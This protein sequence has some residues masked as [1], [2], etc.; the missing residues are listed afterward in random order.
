MKKQL[1]IT[2]LFIILII[3]PV[4]SFGEDFPLRS[5]YPS[6]HPIA[7][8]DLASEFNKGIIIVDVRSKMEYNVIH[9][10][11]SL[12]IPWGKESYS[13]QLLKAAK[14]NKS[15]KI[16]VYCNG[17]TCA[18]S[19]HAAEEAQKLGFT[20]IWVF[21]AGIFEWAKAHSS[22]TV[23]LGKNPADKSKLISKADFNK[24]LLAKNEFYEGASK[25]NSIIIDARDKA[26]IKRN[27]YFG[28]DVMLSPLDDFLKVIKT[29]EFK[30]NAKNKTIYLFDAVGKQVRWL[31]Y[32]L[33]DEGYSNYYFLK[34]GTLSIT[35][36]EG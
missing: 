34:G 3:S 17:I 18:K 1:S 2:L 31:Q 11:K 23:L 4:L 36:N 8:S 29:T 6:V 35:G 22:L 19:Y 5:K 15:T 21:D 33:K 30:T 9:V 32:Y 7:I 12:H 10:K 27:L 13:T 16:A 25:D 28:K 14:G 24:H 26:Q 20:N